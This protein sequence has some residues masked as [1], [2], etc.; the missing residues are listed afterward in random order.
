MEFGSVVEDWLN[1]VL[2]DG[3]KYI[4]LQAMNKALEETKNSK[5][6][7]DAVKHL[8]DKASE[9]DLKKLVDQ[10][11]KKDKNKDIIIYTED[12]M[13]QIFDELSKELFDQNTDC[14]VL[15]ESFKKYF[16]QYSR[17]M[18]KEFSKGERKILE[19]LNSNNK[20][21]KRIQK[22]QDEI[23]QAQK[24]MIKFQE[25][26]WK[27]ISEGK[28]IPFL[29]FQKSIAAEIT[30][31][32]PMITN[33]GNFYDCEAENKDERIKIYSIHKDDTHNDDT[34]GFYILRFLIK[35][36]GT[37]TIRNIKLKGMK[38]WCCQEVDINDELTI[39]V[40]D[41]KVYDDD[42]PEDGYIYC[43]VAEY[44]ALE[45]KSTNWVYVREEDWMNICFKTEKDEDY[46]DFF[47]EY[48]F[49]R[50]RIELE[51]E[52]SGVGEGVAPQ[53]YIYYLYLERE[54]KGEEDICGK[55]VIRSVEFGGTSNDK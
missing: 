16:E 25:E 13:R 38:I 41:G 34:V 20:G 11:I 49:D 21:V 19:L 47:N 1:G 27:L 54:T 22:S 46:N 2:Y 51:L 29:T 40:V 3:V 7:A 53:G 12:E 10:L 4:V 35:N 24:D 5:R 14:E 36:T 50:L 8:P 31:Y 43:S 52:L 55:Y 48:G 45:C 39:S 26:I 30:K 44:K 37:S 17:D 15:W 32:N 9:E 23:K 6:K 42:D 28:N 33:L 18:C